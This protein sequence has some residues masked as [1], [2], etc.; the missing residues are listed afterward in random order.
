MSNISPIYYEDHSAV[1]QLG[2]TEILNQTLDHLSRLKPYDTAT[3][4]LSAND[5]FHVIHSF[6]QDNHSH[7]N[8]LQIPTTIINQIK[9]SKSPVILNN[10]NHLRSNSNFYH[11][12]KNG[13]SI[14][15]P[16]HVNATFM[17][18]LFFLKNEPD[19]FTKLDEPLFLAFSYQIGIILENAN[20]F[21]REKKKSALL[22]K[23]NNICQ[24]I[25]S[26]MNIDELYNKVVDVI[27][28]NFGY[29][30]VA[31]YLVDS[32]K[33]CISLKSISGIYQN[34][35]PP[36]QILQLGQGIVGWVVQS[37]KTVLSNDTKADPHFYNLTPD[38]TPTQSELCV[39][40]K[41]ENNIIGALN[42]E[43]REI[44]DF[45]DDDLNSLEVL[46]NKVGV[47]I[48]NSKLYQEVQENNQRLYDIVSSMGQ[49]IITMDNNYKIQWVNK[50][51]GDW[52]WKTSTII[53]QYCYEMFNNN[54]F[55]SGCPAKKT[56]KSGKIARKMIQSKNGKYFL[57]TCA[58]I[59]DNTG[60][61]NQVIEVFD[62][63]T[64]NIKNQEELKDTR[65]QLEHSKYLAA[66]GELT[67]SIAHE[68]R[69]PL[70]ALSNAIDIL[71]SDLKFEG[72]QNRLMNIAKEE[73]ARVNTIIS[74]YLN[75]ARAP[76]LNLTLN[77]IKNSIEETLT[78]L[79]TDKK[80]SSEIEF[81]TSFADIPPILFDKNLIKQV[82][83]N[84]LINSIE[85]I[86]AKG[87]IEISTQKNNNHIE[88]I[89]SD[90]GKGISAEDLGKIFEPF[91]SL[92]SEG[93]GLGLAIV[94]R[95]IERHEWTI[96]VDSEV[97]KGTMFL[98]GIPL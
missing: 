79:K 61:V 98:I 85:A 72:E 7:K 34:I 59:L 75:F 88:I 5:T 92:K 95:I 20:V 58:P 32:K 1:I 45:D 43:S 71:K 48:Q 19:F 81:K 67:A 84:L 33:K 22:A 44:M 38:K 36:D 2:V 74:Q 77:D 4:C 82:I 65:E 30:N 51:F 26:I 13:S 24:N 78:L 15:I 28:N 52:G 96:H 56:F 70:N 94:R 64:Q 69:N 37:G 3:I 14:F 60:S 49:G 55:C 18:F 83:W 47:A 50:T 53:N 73:S 86:P 12:I 54:T 9:S 57:V 62:D 21:R 11:Q 63:I 66:I 91:Y 10:H 29:D 93:T 17:G 27:Q 76:K 68:I 40:I 35:T 31:L 6:P 87:L 16:I 97:G 39:P 8:Q 46:A 80:I 41:I 90:N 89:I 25:D 42:I 23:I